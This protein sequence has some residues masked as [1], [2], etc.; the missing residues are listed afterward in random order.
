[1][2]KLKNLDDLQ[3]GLL[4]QKWMGQNIYPIK[5]IGGL[6]VDYKWQVPQAIDWL[7]QNGFE[8]KE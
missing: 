5:N 3:G 8:E 6:D 1:M 7:K 4:P 2:P